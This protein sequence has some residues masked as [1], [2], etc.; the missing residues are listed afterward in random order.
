MRI[1]D[2]GRVGIGTTTPGSTLSVNG[3]VSKSSGT[4]DIPHPVLPEPTRLVHS[5]IEGP[6]CDL[7]YR[8]SV[9]LTNGSATVNIDSDCTS[10]AAHAMT[11]GTF[12]A[13][14]A[15]PVCFLQNDD[16][17]D[18]VKGKVSGNILTI[19]CENDES[20]ANINWMVVADRQDSFI[21]QWERTDPNGFLIPEYD[22]PSQ[23]ETV[24]PA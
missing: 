20:S 15:N 9:T 19:T 7:I 13:L 5:F 22:T 17:F 16:T 8:G 3:S 23:Q 6:R 1:T 2:V 4:F 14:C 24:N 18:R 11:E 10:N 21:K 12:V